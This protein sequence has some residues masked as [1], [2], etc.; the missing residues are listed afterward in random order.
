MFGADVHACGSGSSFVDPSLPLSK[1]EG[2]LL[3]LMKFKG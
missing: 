2:C 3:W 1:A